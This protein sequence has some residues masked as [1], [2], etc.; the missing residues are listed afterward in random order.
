[1][2]IEPPLESSNGMISC[3]TC[4]TKPS[5]KLERAQLPYIEIPSLSRYSSYADTPEHI[6]IPDVKEQHD[7]LAIPIILISFG[8]LLFSILS[9]FKSKSSRS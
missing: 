3:P 1:M 6:E 8:L 9:L 4:V 2:T 7:D 5:L